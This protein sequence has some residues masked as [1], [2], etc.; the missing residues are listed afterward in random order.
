MILQ[1][2]EPEDC[3][4]CKRFEGTGVDE[5]KTKSLGL[6]TIAVDTSEVDLLLG[7]PTKTGMEYNLQDLVNEIRC[8]PKRWWI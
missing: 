8:L 2:N 4:N 1:A 6:N 7:D 3:N 5:E